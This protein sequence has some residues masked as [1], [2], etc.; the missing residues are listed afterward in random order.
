VNVSV[1]PI[2][3]RLHLLA[4]KEGSMASLKDAEQ[5][6]QHLE[7]LVGELRT[8]LGN[9]DGDFDKLVSLADE[10]SEEADGLAETFSSINQT[11]M[12]RLENVKGAR[13]GR[14]RS[15]SRQTESSESKT[16]STR[17]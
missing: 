16:A 1:R 4:A 7:D 17:S 3:E 14:S 10:L 9:G 6:T 2:R 5:L 15:S 12:Q 8:E 11:L 13:G